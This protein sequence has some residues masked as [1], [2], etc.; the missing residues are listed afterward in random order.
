MN[1]PTGMG[2]DTQMFVVLVFLSIV[3]VASFLATR[4]DTIRKCLG[5]VLLVAW[6]GFAAYNLFTL[7]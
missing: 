1:E 5:I 3:L 7:V 6:A 4:N 2:D